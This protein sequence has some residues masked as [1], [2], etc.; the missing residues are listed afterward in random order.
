MFGREVENENITHEVLDISNGS[1]SEIL[2]LKMIVYMS[3]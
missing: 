2:K 1:N 3:T